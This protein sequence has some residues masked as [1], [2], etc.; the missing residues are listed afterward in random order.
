MMFIWLMQDTLLVLA[1][2]A[3]E[4]LSLLNQCPQLMV[5]IS[6]LHHLKL[7]D[8][9][10]VQVPERLDTCSLFVFHGNELVCFFF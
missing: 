3:Q 6:P 5:E 1:V 7:N 8:V 9:Q 2:Q 4:R 10:T